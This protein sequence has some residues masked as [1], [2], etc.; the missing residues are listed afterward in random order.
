MKTD[1]NE[2]QFFARMA[3]DRSFS[4]AARRLRV[5]KSTVSRAVRR[6][7]ERLGVRLVERTTRRVSLTEVGEI[8]LNHCRRVIEEA[9]EADRSVGA[10]LAKPRGLL[11]VG[12]PVPFAR[13]V[14]GPMM[15]EFLALYPELQVSIQLLNSNDVFPRDSGLDVVVSAGS[16]GDSSLLVR[17]LLR[18]R[19]GIF[20]S[21]AFLERH[22]RPETPAGLR[23]LPCITTTC[24]QRGGE[25]SASVTWRMRRGDE[26]AE[27]RM[28]ARVAVP[29][30]TVNH[31]LAVDG[32]GVATLSL[33]LVRD[34]VEAGRLVRLLP[35]WELDPVEVYAYYPSRLSASPK[36]RALLEFLREKR[37]LGA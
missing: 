34:D 12:V 3:E 31:Q 30:P 9:E 35:E 21:H 22:G 36:V 17:W 13:Y 28:E 25:P 15:G 19:Q 27:L 4:Q 14:L 16:P 5:P 10:M 26:I 8:Y 29:D 33:S 20:A 2:I 7:E 23:G 1:L 24:D 11:R 37:G 32:V 18:V 6:L